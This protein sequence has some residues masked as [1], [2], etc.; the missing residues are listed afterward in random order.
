M[1]NAAKSGNKP[2]VIRLKEAI[3][4]LEEEENSYEEKKKHNEKE[5]NV[6]Q[7]RCKQID[8]KIY[9]TGITQLPSIDERG[10]VI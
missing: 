5:L 10:Y 8:R 1:K 3:S 4:S 2:K 9:E 7:E 6:L